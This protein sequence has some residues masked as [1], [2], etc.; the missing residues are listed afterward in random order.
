MARVD[1]RVARRI[2][3]HGNSC[4]TRSSQEVRT[5]ARRRAAE[6]GLATELT[7]EGPAIPNRMQ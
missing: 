4:A 1:A 6:R 3:G 7:S 2:P 5:I